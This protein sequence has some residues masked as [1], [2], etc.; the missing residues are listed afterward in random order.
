[1][2]S[3]LRPAPLLFLLSVGCGLGPL[4]LKDSGPTGAE[5][6]GDAVIIGDLRIEPGELTFGEVALNETSVKA[7]VLK[8][9][10]DEG[11][12]VRRA[13][14]D[15]DAAFT[16]E[17]TTALPL[18]LQ[19][20]GEVIVEVGFTPTEASQVFAALALDVATLTEP[21]EVPIRG[22]G[23]AAG[24][25]GADGAGDGADG[26]DGAADGG[27]GGGSEPVTV[28]PASVSFPAVEVG[29]IV[30]ADARITNNAAED[31]LLTSVSGSPSEFSYR[32]GAEITLPQVFSPGS[33]R[34]ISLSWA[35]GSAG[36][37]SGTVS[38]T[39]EDGSGVEHTEE[40][41]VSGTASEPSCTICA[42][43]LEVTT[44]DTPTTLTIRELISCNRSENVELRN[45]GDED[46]DISTIYVNNDFIATCG[47]LSVSGSGFTLSPGESTVVR[48][49]YAAT[50]SCIDV[51]VA[52]LDTNMLHILNNSGVSDYTIA[53]SA[54]ASCLF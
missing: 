23:A 36:T 11:V 18:E 4:T 25:D 39:F 29:G 15:G 35:P 12:V 22:R 10:G 26:A 44:N 14:L 19:G 27:D 43:I 7:V 41:A 1:M 16:I 9:T 54:S 40:I 37:R 45:V 13:Q 5:T 53:V 52:S 33:S 51:P 20:G 8:N 2:R 28:S 47:T 42:P 24:G 48:V 50:E 46:L 6:D 3:L 21:Y 32:R 31:M 34:N 17:S 38:L 49:S 30:Y